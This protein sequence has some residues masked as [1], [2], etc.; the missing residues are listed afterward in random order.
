MD[1]EVDSLQ[2]KIAWNAKRRDPPRDKRRYLNLALHHSEV[3][4][5]ASRRRNG[6][7]YRKLEFRWVRTSVRD[8]K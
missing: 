2:R 3:G 5:N 4:G 7:S 1:L 8:V 6:N